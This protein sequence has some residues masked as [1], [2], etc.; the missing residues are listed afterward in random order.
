MPKSIVAVVDDDPGMLKSIEYLL[1]AHGFGVEVF[2]SAETFTRREPFKGISCLI[3][4]IQLGGMSGFDLR[5]LLSE[6][7]CRFPIIFITAADDE[8]TAREAHDRGCAAF[9][10]KPF[11]PICLI[12][13]IK[14]A[15]DHDP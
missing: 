9:L 2:A 14:Q 8:S 4:D 11:K 13:A 7:G 5:R 15:M 1:D 3:L 10:L 6:R 12:N